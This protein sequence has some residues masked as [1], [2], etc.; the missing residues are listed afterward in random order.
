MF[1]AAVLSIVFMLAVLPNAAVLCAAW[2]QPAETKSAA[3]QHQDAT[4]TLVA[5]GKDSCRP[6]PATPAA[7]LREEAKRGSPLAGSTHLTPLPPFQFTPQPS[8]TG[9][10]DVAS[11]SLA[12]GSP[13]RVIALR[14]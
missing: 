7:F 3:C 14:I 12:D 4:T 11:T 8:D 6:V 10:V 5:T 2:C 1:P 9:H 13:P